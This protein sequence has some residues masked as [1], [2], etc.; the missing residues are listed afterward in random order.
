[1]YQDAKGQRLTLYISAQKAENHDTAFRFSQ[2]DRVA[3][4]Y[5]VDRDYGYALS[6]EIE[7]EALLRV[8][9]AVYKQLNP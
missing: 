4:F 9:N 5:W 7:R 1:M 6:G 2:Q 3:V 8:A